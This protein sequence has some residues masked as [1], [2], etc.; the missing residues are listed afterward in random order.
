[1]AFRVWCNC[2]GQ[3]RFE[4]GWPCLEARKG[5]ATLAK[6][7]TCQRW[8]GEPLH[9]K[10]VLIGI[11]AGQGDM[12]QLCR[13]AEVLKAQGAT[14][15]AVIC[16]PALKTLF[17][18]LDGIDFVI[19]LDEPLPE[20][21]WDLWTPPLSIPHYCQTRLESI[22]ARLPYLHAERKKVDDWSAR[23][24]AIN[25]SSAL[26]VG[27]VWKGNPRFENDAD[28]SLPHFDTLNPLGAIAGIQFFGLQK[29]AG[30]SEADETPISFPV[31]NLGAQ[32]ADFSDTAAIIEN[33]D[34]V[35]SVDTALAHL[36]G[37][38]GKTCWLLLPDYK[39]DW[40][41]LTERNDSP[42]YPGVMRLF[43]QSRAGEWD[44]VIAEVREALWHVLCS[45][46]PLR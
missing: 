23:I 38:L 16:H 15:V 27:L 4:E 43:R 42:W 37:A 26:R 34:L 3:G 21:G 17:N 35:I 2:P 46:Q 29:G 8:Q 13:Y 44:A 39:T 32:I 10:S 30:E 22:P 40:R 41:W 18:S 1:M 5:Y 19:A 7:L 45:N 11:E 25:P 24:K 9:G 36:T 33:L 14:Q 28:R 31:V 6:L 12:I 20:V